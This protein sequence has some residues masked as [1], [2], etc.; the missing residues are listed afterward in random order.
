V[1]SN[2]SSNWGATFLSTYQ[3]ESA[4]GSGGAIE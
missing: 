4:P 3:S 1:P 2:A